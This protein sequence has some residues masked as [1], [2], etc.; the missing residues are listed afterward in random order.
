M[1]YQIYG[2][3]CVLRLE[4][5]EELIGQIAAV[6]AAADIRAGYVAS[7]VAA[8]RSATVGLY[9]LGEKRFLPHTLDMPLEL[10]ALGGNISRMDGEPYLHL[11]AVLADRDAATYGGHLSQAVV[12]ATAEIFLKIL[13]M[14][15]GRRPDADTGLNLITLA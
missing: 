13:P 8:L 7:A 9:D 5:G 15:L 11:H 1:E 6:C 14:D 10:A 4:P 3:T 2:D 12:S